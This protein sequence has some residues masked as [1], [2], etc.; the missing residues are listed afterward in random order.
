MAFD[1]SDFTWE[2]YEMNG[3]AHPGVFIAGLQESEGQSLTA[4]IEPEGYTNQHTH[5]GTETITVLEGKA[6]LTLHGTVRKMREGDSVAVPAGAVH[7][8]RNEGK[9]ALYVYA[10]FAP[11]FHEQETTLVS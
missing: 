3:V 10:E 8:L 2:P 1:F 11:S 6:E 7:S 5:T 9:K 4:K